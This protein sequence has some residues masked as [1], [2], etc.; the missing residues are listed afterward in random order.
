MGTDTQRYAYKILRGKA[1]NLTYAQC[2]TVVDKAAD[3]IKG[4]TVHRNARTES[5]IKK[6][7]H[8]RKIKSALITHEKECGN[9]MNKGE[10]VGLNV[11]ATQNQSTTTGTCPRM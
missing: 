6:T 5:C 3:Q 10:T 11:N 8:I 4:G 7:F 1:E 9:R 2:G